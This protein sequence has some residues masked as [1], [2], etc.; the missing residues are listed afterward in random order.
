MFPA[1]L[2]DS[3]VHAAADA[4][5]RLADIAAADGGEI[6]EEF[7]ALRGVV[8]RQAV[9]VV[10]SSNG[11]GSRSDRHGR[12]FVLDRGDG[13]GERV[14]VRAE[15]SWPESVVVVVVVVDVAVVVGEGVLG[16]CK[17]SRACTSL[18]NFIVLTFLEVAGVCNAAVVKTLFDELPSPVGA[19][20]TSFVYSMH[21]SVLNTQS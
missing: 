14:V 20:A 7:P 6:P 11:S 19:V 21:Y 2:H 5:L 8:V 3:V 15:S 1:T 16:C 18:L 13:G 9:D 4:R 17:A 12:D 10:W